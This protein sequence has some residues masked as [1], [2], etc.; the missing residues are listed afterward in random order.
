[1][2]VQLLPS[3]AYK[4][5][6]KYV[7]FKLYFIDYAITIVLI[8]PHLHALIQHP[9][10]RQAIPTPLFLSIGHVYKFFGYYISYTEI[11]SPMANNYQF[12]LLF[13]S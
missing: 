8:F 10:Y 6:E 2:F 7:L 1:M 13:L 11:Y 4:S 5:Y 9:P 3:V 12:V